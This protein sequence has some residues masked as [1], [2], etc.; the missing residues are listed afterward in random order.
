M[1]IKIFFFSGYYSTL[2]KFMASGRTVFNNYTVSIFILHL[3]P[4]LEIKSWAASSLLFKTFQ[5]YSF[6]TKPTVGKQQTL[7]TSYSLIIH[8]MTLKY[9]HIYELQA[10]KP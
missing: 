8:V 6:N 5:S 9:N 3:P 10:F 1:F 4:Y 2:P 7:E